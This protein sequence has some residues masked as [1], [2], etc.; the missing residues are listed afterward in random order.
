VGSTQKV[1]KPLYERLLSV[2]LLQ[3]EE[4]ALTL[5]FEEMERRTG[6]EPAT[7]CLEGRSSTIELPPRKR[8]NGT[9]EKLRSFFFIVASTIF[10][11]IM[12]FQRKPFAVKCFEH[13]S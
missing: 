8:K 12:L 6:L 5:L 1:E 4:L 13:A 10:V 3:T 7:F 9:G 11:V 2:F